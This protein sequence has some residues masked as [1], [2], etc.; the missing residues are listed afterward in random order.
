MA[1]LDAVP[2]DLQPLTCLDFEPEEARDLT[3]LP[4]A[5]RFKLDE[6]G[7]RCS[8]AQWQALSFAKRTELLNCLPGD[9][10]ST[11]ARGAGAYSDS[12]CAAPPS[13]FL[14]YARAKLVEKS[15]YRTGRSHG[16]VPPRPSLSSSK[17]RCD[18]S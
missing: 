5:V 18:G 13:S 9:R 10:F 15:A 17:K 8:L 3:W 4:L 14:E 12:R 11:L 6:V 2:Q 16:S 7:L 1:M